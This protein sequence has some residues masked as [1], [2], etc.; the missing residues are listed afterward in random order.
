MSWAN[1]P[2]GSARLTEPRPQFVSR[3]SGA[4]FAAQPTLGA[5]PFA[6]P[7]QD[8]ARRPSRATPRGA[9]A[10]LGGAPHAFDSDECPVCLDVLDGFS[11]LRRE[12][13]GCGHS[14]CGT[15]VHRLRE[16][17]ALAAA[18]GS[19]ADGSA[20]TAN[21]LIA[22][23]CPLCRAPLT[24]AAPEPLT[25][26]AP[27]PL[28]T[29]AQPRA[30]RSRASHLTEPAAVERVREL[31]A[32][33]TGRGAPAHPSWAFAAHAATGAGPAGANA[34]AHPA[35]PAAGADG[36]V[37]VWVRCGDLRLCDNPA[38]AFAEASGRAVVPVYVAPPVEEEGP[39]PLRGAAR[40]WLHHSI[41]A[42]RNELRGCPAPAARRGAESNA[43]D[44]AP[45]A[46]PAAGALRSELVLR[47]ARGGS[48]AEA[49]FALVAETGASTV[50]WN[51]LY[52]PWWAERDDMV[53]AMLESV[54][55]RVERFEGN[56]LHAP[57]KVAPDR[58]EAALA[59]GFGTIAFWQTAVVAA[60]G[61]DRADGPPP[62]PAVRALRQPAAGFPPSASLESL[63]LGRLPRAATGAAQPI[64]WA[65]G[66]RAFWGVGERA[67]HRA[68]AEF[69]TTSLGAYA[70]AARHRADHSATARI[71]PHVRFGELSARQVVAAVRR[72]SGAAGAAALARRLM[73]RDLATWALRRFPASGS[74]GFRAQYETEAWAGGAAELR[75]WRHGRTGY[76]LVDA[77]MRQ[78]WRVGWMP[79]YLRHVVGQFLVEYLHVD[80]R[81]GL[82]WFDYALVDA[83]VAINAFMWA[84]G[85]HCGLDQWCFVMHPVH[86][87]KQCDPDG[88]YVRAYCPELSEL[89]DEFVHCPWEAPATLRAAAHVTLGDGPSCTYPARVLVDLE[90]ARRGSIAAVLA[91]RRG[92]VG[93]ALVAPSGNDVFELADGRRLELVTRKDFIAEQLVVRQSA[94]PKR[95]RA[96]RARPGAAAAVMREEAGRGRGGGGDDGDD[97]AGP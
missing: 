94:E 48:S 49:L 40:Y 60:V 57:D 13:F 87:A 85:G 90:R 20:A 16:A 62:L 3:Q 79:N 7:K 92:A 38:L 46:L 42:L 54:G 31:P 67:A 45:A 17:S 23:L 89:P 78:L 71:S 4:L 81:Q 21:A 83:D 95:E 86:A 82:R 58:C 10:S 50:A 73:W 65:V 27:E 41:G 28:P 14:A 9:A 35:T 68:L 34:A 37:L 5:R 76:P 25:P 84:N 39:W 12:R 36:P 64:D 56:V 15:C 2:G 11:A 6:R 72:S 70:S 26:A 19:R 52:E 18:S 22:P 75:A 55:V 43:D 74:V 53:A 97:A 32:V 61:I 69:V 30:P 29:F 24:P 80:W 77:A 66:V 88:A 1:L 91:V 8:I 51:D 47:D 44:D 33:E 93:A 63:G 59:S 96:R